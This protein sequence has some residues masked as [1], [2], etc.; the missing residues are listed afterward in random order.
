MSCELCS[1][2]FHFRCMRFK[3]DVDLLATKDLCAASVWHP[4][5]CLFCERWRV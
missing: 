1:G 2:W 3:E 4:E 5:L